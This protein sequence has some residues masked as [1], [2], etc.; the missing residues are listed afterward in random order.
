MNI[1]EPIRRSLLFVLG[2]CLWAALLPAQQADEAS[3]PATEYQERSFSKTGLSTYRS[4]PAYQ[5]S[6]EN[7]KPIE[8]KEKERK[9]K[10]RQ[11]NTVQAPSGPRGDFGPIA[12]AI[13]WILIIGMVVLLLYQLFKIRFKGLVKKRSDEAVVTAPRAEEAEDIR[14]MEF[15]NLLQDAINQKK[16]R[17]AVRLLYLQSLRQ[18]QDRSLIQ[19][20]REKT[21]RDYLREIQDQQLRPLFDELTFTFDYVWYGEFPVDL[22]HF[23]T[24]RAGFIEFDQALRQRDAK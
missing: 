14:N 21:N 10:L 17:Q 5:Y 13:F 22:N 6:R 23:N 9:P 4:D 7:P 19:W 16:Y 8:R 12:K 18:L 3:K 15:E 11:R 2:F 24:A 1:T 20:R